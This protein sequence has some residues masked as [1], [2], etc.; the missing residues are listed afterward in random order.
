MYLSVCLVAVTVA[1]AVAVASAGTVAVG[2]AVP[3]LCAQSVC[4]SV[5]PVRQIVQGIGHPGLDKL[6]QRRAGQ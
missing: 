3:V 2:E 1:V 6:A 4:D 5:V